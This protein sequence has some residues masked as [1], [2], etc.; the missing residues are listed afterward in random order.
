M[1]TICVILGLLFALPICLLR[2]FS[3]KNS[4]WFFKF[5]EFVCLIFAGI[6]IKSEGA[7]IVAKTHPSV[8]IG[9]HQHNMDALAVAQIFSPH[10][11]VLGKF[12]LGLIPLFGQVYALTG[13]ILVKRGNRKKAMESM[14]VI[15]KKVLDN[16]LT[17]LVFPEGTRNS[18]EELGAFKKGAFYTAIRTQ[19]P[20]IPFS[21]SKYSRNE[22]LNK[23]GLLKI[24]V[25]VHEP[26]E[27]V[28]LTTQDI[29][30]LMQETKK[31][32]QDG[33]EELNKNYQ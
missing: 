32:I 18:S 33:I 22:N 29:P 24:Y 13:N 26:I 8:L 19:T 5:F 11:I 17:V 28:G 31:I 7:D 30:R 25:K 20:L 4:Q 3:P 16:K 1:F 23:F 6:S 21:V 15:E 9:N 10:S 14:K 12:E 2:P 27:T